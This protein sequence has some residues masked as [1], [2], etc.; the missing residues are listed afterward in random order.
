MG[1]GAVLLQSVSSYGNKAVPQPVCACDGA[2]SAA[3]AE[4][5]ANQAQKASYFSIFSP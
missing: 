1:A 2:M 5:P 4:T 3:S